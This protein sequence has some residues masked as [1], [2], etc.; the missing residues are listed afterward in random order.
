M[1]V[2]TLNSNT[3]RRVDSATKNPWDCCVLYKKCSLYAEKLEQI[4]RC[5]PPH[6]A[7]VLNCDKSVMHILGVLQAMEM[8]DLWLLVPAVAVERFIILLQNDG[9]WRPPSFTAQKGRNHKLEV[10]GICPSKTPLIFWKACSRQIWLKS[11]FDQRQSKNKPS[12]ES[13]GLTKTSTEFWKR[14]HFGFSSWKTTGHLL[15]PR[16]RKHIQDVDH[17][18]S[19]YTEGNFGADETCSA[20]M[21]ISPWVNCQKL[22][23]LDWWGIIN[24]GAERHWRFVNKESWIC[25]NVSWKFWRTMCSD[26]AFSFNKKNSSSTRIKGWIIEVISQGVQSSN[27]KNR[28]HGSV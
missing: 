20:V 8:T 13:Q 17:N 24:E 23:L 10:S 12:K 15:W 18:H 27:T 2:V 21:A 6:T 7:L 11:S 22:P 19:Y 14:T 5:F 4:L 28:C 1:L 16:N 26:L 3:S 25:L 9:Q